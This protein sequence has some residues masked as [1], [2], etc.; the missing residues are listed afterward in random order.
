MD[1]SGLFGIIFLVFCAFFVATNWVIFT[2][3]G[4]PG[5][6]ALV[7]FYN[8][9]ILIKISGKPGYW[10]VLMLVPLV[11]F[12]IMIMTYIALADKFGKSGAFAAGLIF[13]SPIFFP[14]LAFGSAT[15]ANKSVTD[16][17]V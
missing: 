6:K 11:N 5:W 2:K 16:G 12:V 14:I 10:F 17:V 15:Y 4:E 9:Y 3:A 1:S 7:P 13:L 8:T